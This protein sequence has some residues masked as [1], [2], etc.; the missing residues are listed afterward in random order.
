MSNSSTYGREPQ[1]MAI[2]T[3]YNKD[4]NSAMGRLLHPEKQQGGQVDAHVTEIKH[5][6]QHQTRH[7][8]TLR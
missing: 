6:P 2:D 8:S 5:S 3:S 1:D 7:S 4:A